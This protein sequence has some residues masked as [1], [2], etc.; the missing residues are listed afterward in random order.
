MVEA[1]AIAG[2]GKGNDFRVRGGRT[3]AWARNNF[4]V[5]EADHVSDKLGYWDGLG[6]GLGFRNI[7]RVGESELCSERGARAR[8]GFWGLPTCQS[9]VAPAW[10]GHFLH[11]NGKKETTIETPR[12]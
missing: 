2:D 4:A 12:T 5:L 11:G 10:A 1:V 6:F 3:G 8:F 9:V 7:R